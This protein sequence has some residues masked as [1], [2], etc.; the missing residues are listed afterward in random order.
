MYALFFDI[1]GTLV[2]FKTHQVPESTVEALTLAKEKGSK[3]YISTG[4]PTKIIT[5]LHAIEHLIDGYITIN[6]AYCYVG[7]E[8]VCCHPIPEK[9]VDIILEDA[10]R[11][12]KACMVVGETDIIL[13]NYQPI[14]HK[15]FYEQLDVKNLNPHLTLDDIKGQKIL[16]CT[17]FIDQE[18][19]KSLMERLPGCVSGRWHP[20]FTDITAKEADK[21]KGLLA[22][23]AHE[24]FDIRHTMAFGDGG[25]DIAILKQAGIGVALG[26]AIPELKKVA[27]YVTTSIDDHGI[28]HALKH[29]GII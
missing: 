2:S 5:N 23:A 28:Y 29:F 11:K 4:R 27:N 8:V 15:I 24:G 6:G 25:N 26:N 19:E 16:Q 12:N 10:R 21:G 14:V 18:E 1:D 13:Y 3:V 20:Q 17:Y 22:M 9:E 7:R